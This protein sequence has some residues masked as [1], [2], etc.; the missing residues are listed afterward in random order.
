MSVPIMLSLY[1]LH[2]HNQSN[3]QHPYNVRDPKRFLNLLAY[4]TGLISIGMH[5]AQL[6]D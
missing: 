3:V 1:K 4:V 6:K 2:V 5:T